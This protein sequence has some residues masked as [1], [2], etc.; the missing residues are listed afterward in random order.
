MSKIRNISGFPEWTPAQKLA[1]NEVIERIRTVFQSFGFTP[2]ET[3]AVELF[4]TIAAKG[5]VDFDEAVGGAGGVAG[6]DGFHGLH[7]GDGLA[8]GGEVVV[9]QAAGRGEPLGPAGGGAAEFH[10]GDFADEPLQH[11]HAV[12]P[13]APLPPGLRKVP[14]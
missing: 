14:L 5:V 10:G 4:S 3:P 6:E 13:L 12:A 8:V 7:G 2:I 9:G 1:E 11:L